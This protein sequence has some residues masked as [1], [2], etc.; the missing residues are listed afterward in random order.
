MES[1]E[2]VRS[3]VRDLKPVRRL[4]GVEWRTLLWAGFALS[5]VW[6]GTYALGA[7]SDRFWRFLDPAHLRDNA[8]L[9]LVFVL[10]A[11]SAFQLSV[12][13]TERSTVARMLPIAGL[14]LWVCLRATGHSPGT[15]DTLAGASAW[16]NGWPCFLKMSCLA[17]LPTF[18]VLFM[19]RKAAPLSPGWTGSFALL[20]AGSLSIIGS[21]IL[22]AKDAPRHVFLW[23]FA[24]VV[25]A[26]LVGI[27]LGRWLLTRP[28]IANPATDP[29]TS[30]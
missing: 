2:V 1:E 16:M 13:G 9:L 21:Q 11:R 4:R 19:L 24:P 17:L 28:S 10:S 22:C 3:L 6:I 8:L 25:A 27:H 29:W 18:A 20:S 14:L 12:P 30:Q 26:G 5:C 23:H 7:R 15:S